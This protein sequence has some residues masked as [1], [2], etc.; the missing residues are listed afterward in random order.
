MLAAAGVPVWKALESYGIDPKTVFERAAVDPA[1][2][3]VAGARYGRA[4]MRRLWQL[5]AEATNDPCFGLTAGEHW[6][7][8]VF[9]GLGY[10]WLA[11]ETLYDAFNRLVRYFAVLTG[12]ALVS[13]G[14]GREGCR[15]ELRRSV[16]VEDWPPAILDAFF[17]TV[18]S[19][20]RASYGDSFRPLFMEMER[21]KPPCHPRFQSFFRCEV[22]F[23]AQRNTLVM[24]HSELMMPLPTAN[25]ELALASEKIISDYLSRFKRGDL[26]DRARAR[27]MEQLPAGT[28]THESLAEALNLSVRTLQ[29]RLR[30]RNTSFT[31]ILEQTRRELARD[32]MDQGSMSNKEIAYLLGF[33]EPSNFSRAFKRWTGLSPSEFR[34]SA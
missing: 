11:S 1:K 17:S 33:S 15:L 6:H 12:G 23:G 21:D 3:D 2:L 5:A 16:E 30:D 8:S 18:I 34:A 25:T 27:L 22:A 14:A 7:P 31:K 26:V 10:A 19:M 20:C 4:E 32:Y 29:R 9:H 13:F 24:D 28:P